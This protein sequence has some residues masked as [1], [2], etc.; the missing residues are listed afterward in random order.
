MAGLSSAS[1]ADF[2]PAFPL[3][4]DEI[5]VIIMILIMMMLM[6]L[7]MIMI[8]MIMVMMMIL[9]ILTMLMMKNTYSVFSFMPALVSFSASEST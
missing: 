1:A 8:L 9:M 2:R 3:E 4:F 6:I 5:M 7:M